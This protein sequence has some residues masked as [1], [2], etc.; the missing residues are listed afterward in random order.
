MMLTAIVACSRNRVIGRDNKL[1]WHIPEDLKF[2]RDTTKNHIMIMGRKT[3][4]SL[5][6][7]L[8]HRYHI[9]ITRQKNY[10]VDH[11]D[12]HVVSSFDEA[13]SFAKTLLAKYPPEVFIVGGGEIF[14][15]TMSMMD[16]IYLTLIE[17]DVEGDAYFPQIPATGWKKVSARRVEANP[18]YTFECWERQRS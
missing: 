6:K 16:R 11:P 4:E 10:H 17:M 5:P 2:F 3:F 13:V 14:T 1:P 12:V 8:P 9:V 7:P 18:S 15:Q